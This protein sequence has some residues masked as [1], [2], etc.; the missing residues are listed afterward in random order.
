VTS[1]RPDGS[2]QIAAIFQPSGDGPF[3]VVVYFHSAEGLIAR[4]IG[5]TLASNGYLVVV[6]CHGSVAF[7]CRQVPADG[8]DALVDLARAL[9]SAGKGQVGLAGE[10]AGAALAESLAAR[11][12]D[13]AAVVADSGTSAASFPKAPV[14]ILESV[15]DESSFLAAARTYESARRERGLAVEAQYYDKGGHIVLGSPETRDDA[16]R[17]L[18]AFLGRYLSAR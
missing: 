2:G 15:N 16:T 11:R 9:P 5:E 6:G 7:R 4:S 17:R 1:G 8:A 3:P 13:V 18:I 10:S 12:D 14:L